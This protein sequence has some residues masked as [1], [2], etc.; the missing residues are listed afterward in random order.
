MKRIFI[1]CSLMAG[2]LFLNSNKVS[3]QSNE[4]S[5]S[6]N[7]SNVNGFTTSVQG[8]KG[9][10]EDALEAYFKKTFDSKSSSSK[11]FKMF[12]GVAWPEI[13]TEK[14]DVYYKVAGKKGNNTITMLVSKGYDNFVSS[15]SDPAIAQGVVNFMNTI[16]DK[17]MVINNANAVA[18][19]ENSLKDAQREYDRA[20]KKGSDLKDDQEKIGKAIAS[21]EKEISE[22]EQALNK[23]KS[24]LESAKSL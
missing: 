13:A 20:V 15:Q 6:Y 5:V 24:A 4:S 14:L 22:K 9:A 19:A 17:V 2:T 3:A 12:K 8:D 16:K 11:G 10:V 1:I 18:A 21:Q 23:A 7:K